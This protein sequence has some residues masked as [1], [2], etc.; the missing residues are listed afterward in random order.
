MSAAAP[1]LDGEL[2]Q[3]AA[4][5]PKGK[6]R[7]F[8]MI[9]QDEQRRFRGC[10]ASWFPTWIALKRHLWHGNWARLARSELVADTGYDLRTIKRTLRALEELE[11]V[12]IRRTKGG[13]YREANWMRIRELPEVI[14][15][16]ERLRRRRRPASS[17][18]TPRPADELGA[19]LPGPFVPAVAAAIV[20]PPVEER[21]SAT[22]ERW[23]S[24]VE[25]LGRELPSHMVDA[26]FG[27]ARARAIVR[28][29]LVVEVASAHHAT[30]IRDN[31]GFVL[32][33]VEGGVV[34]V[35][36]GAEVP[37]PA[38]A[39]RPVDEPL[40]DQAARMVIE[41]HRF[42]RGVPDHVSVAP[43]RGELVLAR[44]LL[45]EHGARA[46]ELVAEAVRILARQQ[47]RTGVVAATF[48][49]L[50]PHLYRVGASWPGQEP[51]PPDPRGRRRP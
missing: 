26:W 40:D 51:R 47:E 16:P 22:A 32:A 9:T 33:R 31:L 46:W 24:F 20:E 29:A 3:P 10:P 37:E 25:L 34:V 44:G 2:K 18:G 49:Y 48:L 36:D 8:A 11:I 12:D 35:E 39:D 45:E 30:W 17:A 43:T 13:S 28:G 38:P 27:G 42:V 15:V 7:G 50:R 23:T 41:F 5:A 19:A 1:R 14:E 4:E 6:R 21:P